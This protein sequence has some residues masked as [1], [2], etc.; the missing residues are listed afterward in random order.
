VE[1]GFVV[2]AKAKARRNWA[3]SRKVWEARRCARKQWSRK[4][5]SYVLPEV[6]LRRHQF[7]S[8][9]S[10]YQNRTLCSTN[11]RIFTGDL[12]TW[13]VAVL[14]TANVSRTISWWRR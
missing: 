1:E 11:L 2:K 3:S 7:R 10:D 5:I 8:T 13:L 6:S 9:K 4:R 14:S 12:L